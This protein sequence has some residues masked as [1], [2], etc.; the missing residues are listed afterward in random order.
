MNAPP[1]SGEN[2]SR[3]KKG[4][5]RVTRPI[6]T[7]SLSDSSTIRTR[8]QQAQH[9]STGHVAKRYNSSLPMAHTLPSS[10][11]NA[12]SS[13]QYSS[14]NAARPVPP[15]HLIIEICVTEHT[16]RCKKQRAQDST[17][18]TIFAIHMI[19]CQLFLPSMRVRVI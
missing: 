7:Q 16:D 14:D 9:T 19:L 8:N 11:S 10:H 17:V 5:G 3:N 4:E 13:W 1:T 2:T 15:R 6:A 12:E 18:T